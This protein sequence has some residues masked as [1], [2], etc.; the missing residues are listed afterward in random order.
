MKALTSTRETGIVGDEGLFDEII[1]HSKTE[2]LD[3]HVLLHIAHF[4]KA[5]AGLYRVWMSKNGSWKQGPFIAIDFE[6]HDKSTKSLK[7]RVPSG[8]TESYSLY[9]ELYLQI[10]NALKEGQRVRSLSRLNINVKEV[11]LIKIKERL[12]DS[13]DYAK[14]L[15]KHNG[16]HSDT[17]FDEHEDF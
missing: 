6:Y 17:I 14:R 9:N 13:D 8:F 1:T 12:S 7:I 16:S 11:Y 2:A 5:P 3:K 10:K 15:R 4:M